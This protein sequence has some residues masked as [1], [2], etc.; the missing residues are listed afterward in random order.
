MYIKNRA[1]ALVLRIFIFAACGYALVTMSNLFG[2]GFTARALAYYTNLSS[3]ALMI[4]LLCSITHTAKDIMQ[5]GIGGTSTF[6]PAVKRPFVWMVTITVVIY[7]FILAPMAF[8]MNLTYQ[9]FSLPDILIHYVTPL[10]FILDWLLFDEKG[11]TKI[12][13][14]LKW[15]IIP[16]AYV[17]FVFIRAEVGQPLNRH[18]TRFPYF[19]LDIDILPVGQVAGY[20][21]FCLVGFIALGYI[22]FLADKYINRIPVKGRS[23]D[24]PLDL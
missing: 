1:A 24:R 23:V 18:G 22:Y 6:L 4:Y 7:H 21:L 14:P 8:R 20:L 11:R 19:F 17:V 3:I 5:K 2:G 10:G 16:F 15:L 12:K 9:L 13:D